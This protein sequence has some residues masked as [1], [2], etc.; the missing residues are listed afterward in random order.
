MNARPSPDASCED[1]PNL[2]RERFGEIPDIPDWLLRHSEI[3]G[4]A[5]HRSHRIF[6]DHKVPS[7][8][9]RTLLAAAFSAPSKSDLQQSCVVHV[10]DPEIKAQVA[11]LIPSMPWIADAPELLVFCA[12]NRRIRRICEMRGIPFGNDHFD[13][14]FNAAVDAALVIAGFVRAAQAAGLGCCPLSVIRNHALEVAG[15]LALPDHVFP[16]AGLVA[17]WPAQ[18]RK[19][20]PRLPLEVFVHE[21]RYGDGDLKAQVDRYDARRHRLLPI[22]PERRRDC[23]RFGEVEFYGWSED[24]ARQVAETERE[25]FGDFL[26]S[27]GFRLD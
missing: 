26:R 16:V 10:I 11:A 27:K 7:A 9:L 17:G 8:L 13:S 12:D 6:T 23:E 18:E 24:K 21:D 19:V 3:K 22:S 5:G 20:V 25:G 15:L 14:V 1:L 4:I 2:L